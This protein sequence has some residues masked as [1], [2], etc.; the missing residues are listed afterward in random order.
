MS[1]EKQKP[2]RRIR[3]MN[4]EAAEWVRTYND[5]PIKSYTFQKSYKDK[6]DNWQHTSSFGIGD[7]PILASLVLCIVGQNV[8][9][10][11]LDG[12]VKETKVESTPT[13]VDEDSDVPF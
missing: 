3:L 9:N 12:Q 11:L 2:A 1:E 13:V 8:K 6:D 10:Q 5:K 7:L 4:I